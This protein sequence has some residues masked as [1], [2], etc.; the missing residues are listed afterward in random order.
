MAANVT[1]QRPAFPFRVRQQLCDAI[2]DLSPMR[3]QDRRD[4]VFD[5]LAA[6]FPGLRS[7]RRGEDP[8][9]DLMQLVSAACEY[10]GALRAILDILTFLFKGDPRLPRIKGV[11]DMLDP[12]RLLEEPERR[13]LL[14]LLSPAE[15]ATLARA[16]HYGTGTT[17]NEAALDPG[18]I[19]ALVG[20]LEGLPGRRDRLPA[21]FDFIDHVAHR[22]PRSSRVP[23]HEWMDDVSIR[24]GYKDRSAVDR[25]CHATDNRLASS[26]RF[27]LVAELRPDQLREDRFFLAAWRQHEDEAEEPLYQSDQSVRWDEAITITHDLMHRMAADTQ[28]TAE[29]QVLELIV[30]RSLVTHPIDQWQVDLLLPAA[31]GTNY[32]LV[33]RSFDRLAD[34]AL[35]GPWARNWRWI[36]END[37]SAGVGALLEIESH[38]LQEAHRSRA[39][40]LRDGPPAILFMLAALPAGDTLGTDLYTAGIRGGAPVMVWSRNDDVAEDLATRVRAACIE[41]LLTLRDHIFQLRLTALEDK[42][43]APA[44]FHASIVFDDFDRIPERFR[45]RSRLH[46]PSTVEAQ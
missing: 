37:R 27:Y 42:D 24:I 16:F 20:H 19:V 29:E 8:A 41:G 17:V 46:S 14:E 32:P 5:Q 38:D 28:G 39:A 31:I 15:P 3:S 44:G 35:H 43:S 30:P 34:R 33:L 11:I 10:P 13:H 22:L 21:L 26:G 23:L 1:S 9:M 40:L 36:K 6:D 2:L 45:G 12:E 4:H 18:D 7:T 25:L